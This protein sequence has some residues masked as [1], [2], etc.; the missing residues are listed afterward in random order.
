MAQTQSKPKRISGILDY[1]QQDIPKTGGDEE[2]VPGEDEGKAKPKDA[3][4]DP[5]AISEAVPMA[6]NND[7]IKRMRRKPLA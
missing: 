6:D 7:K 1:L 5:F 3:V 2:A 4:A